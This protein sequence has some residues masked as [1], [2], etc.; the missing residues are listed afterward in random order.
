MICKF[1]TKKVR[2]N[3]KTVNYNSA[4]LEDHNK[5]KQ[6]CVGVRKKREF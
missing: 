3:K 2:N 5:V 4:P 6:H 1:N